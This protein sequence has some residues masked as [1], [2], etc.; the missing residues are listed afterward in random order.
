MTLT[1]TRYRLVDWQKKTSIRT[2]VIVVGA[3]CVRIC[4]VVDDPVAAS[5]A[6]VSILVEGQTTGRRVGMTHVVAMDNRSYGRIARH[7]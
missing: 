4:T 1:A 7:C 2:P 5:A 6:N 3:R